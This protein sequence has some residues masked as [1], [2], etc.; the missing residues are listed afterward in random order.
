MFRKTALT[1]LVAAAIATMPLTAAP[2]RAADPHDI[3]GGAIALGLIGAI[4]ANESNRNDTYSSQRHRTQ[5]KHVTVHR[6]GNVTHRHVQRGHHYHGKRHIKRYTPKPKDCLRQRWTTK[7]WQKYYSSQ[8]LA[9][10]GYR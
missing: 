9:K 8:C 1:G 5:K 6:H 3:I 4:I 2:A 7:G 10:H